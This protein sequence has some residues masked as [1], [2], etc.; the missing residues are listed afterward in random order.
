MKKLYYAHCPT[1]GMDYKMPSSNWF[2][3]RI[4]FLRFRSDKKT[5]YCGGDTA[6]DPIQFVVSKEK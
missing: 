6:N 2:M 1:C 4:W 3:A 5:N